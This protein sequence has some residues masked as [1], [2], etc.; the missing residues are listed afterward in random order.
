MNTSITQPGTLLLI[1]SNQNLTEQFKA[2]FEKLDYTVL[3]ARDGNQSLD[4]LRQTEH[5]PDLVVIDFVLAEQNGPEVCLQLKSEDR[6]RRI[7]ILMFAKE[8]KLYYMTESYR[9]GAEYYIVMQD[10]GLRTLELRTQSI[11]SR[12]LRRVTSS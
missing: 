10:D 2:H 8:D 6:F 7:P 11:L 9:A 12:H 5:G 1:E 4:L 3:T